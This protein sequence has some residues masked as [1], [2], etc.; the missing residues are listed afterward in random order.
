MSGARHIG[1]TL[2]DLMMAMAVIAIVA[3]IATPRYANAVTRYRAEAAA[4]RVAADLALARQTAKSTS[5]STTVQFD[6]ADDS[7]LIPN[8]RELDTV[9]T[10]YRV[11]LQDPPYQAQIVSV[12]LG[13]DW[14]I[15]FDGF[16]IPDSGG[17]VIVQAGDYQ[18][19][20][21]VDPE[22]GAVEIQ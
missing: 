5:S 22:T 1:F 6:A 18:Y 16:G 10:M 12:D 7:Y 4:R 2:L 20:V 8:V 17:F 19:T 21:V 9:G 13:G 11:Q 15:I 3:A 14:Q